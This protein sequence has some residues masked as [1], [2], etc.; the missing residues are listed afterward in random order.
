MTDKQWQKLIKK[1]HSLAIKHRIA[2]QEAEEEYV[3]RFGTHPSDWDDDW[4]IDHVHY[5]MG[6]DCDIKKITEEALRHKSYK[7]DRNG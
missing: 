7:E 4:W 6:S 1:A 3:R 2:M 5:G